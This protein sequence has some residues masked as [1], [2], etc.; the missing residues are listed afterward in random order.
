[1]YIISIKIWQT[2]YNYKLQ[3]YYR[4]S[5]YYAAGS[6]KAKYLNQYKRLQVLHE[7]VNKAH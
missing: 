5:T 1:M 2:L 4:F 7:N 3:L 6:F